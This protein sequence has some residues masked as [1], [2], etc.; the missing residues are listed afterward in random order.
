MPGSSGTCVP[1]SARMLGPNHDFQTPPCGPWRAGKTGRGVA[2]L[3]RW[4]SSVR[5]IA[6][7]AGTPGP[8]TY[9][10]ASK[11]VLTILDWKSGKAIYPE[12]FLQNVAYRHAAA[13]G[14]LPSAQGLIVRLPKRLD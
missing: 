6:S 14:E 2:A 10:R 7:T 8:W 4:P 11:G 13:R 5:S 9:T 12:A 1:N 3:S